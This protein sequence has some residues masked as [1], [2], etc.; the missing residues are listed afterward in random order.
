VSPVTPS[1][2][3]DIL[4]LPDLDK[5]EDA[6]E[7]DVGHFE[8]SL[9]DDEEAP[10]E[11]IPVDTF[12]VDIQVLT[13]SGSNEAA[14][15]LDVGGNELME[16]LPNDVADQDGESAHPAGAELDLHLDT[17]LESDEPSSD[18]ELGDDGLEALPELVNEDGDGD[19]GP[20]HERAYLPSAPEGAVAKGPSYDSEWLLLGTPCS[21][22]WAGQGLV[23]GAAEHLM[24]FGT[25]RR[26]QDLPART[27]TLSL[28][29]LDD[30]RVMLATTRGLLELTPDG[31]AGLTELS[32][33]GR[34]SASAGSDVVELAAAHGG[35][36]ALW[37]RLANGELLRKRDGVWGRHEAGGSV[38]ALSSYEEHVTLLVV[39]HRP[40]LQVSSDGGSSFREI[41][42]PEPA[43]TVALGSGATAVSHGA[44][45]ALADAQ[46]GLCIS[47][48][49]GETFRMVVGAVNV[50]AMAIGQH[51]GEN[52]LFAA[53]YRES[54]DVS[55][56]ISVAF[57]SATPLSIAEL[58]GQPD[59]DAEETGR[60]QA[61][62]F[63]GAELWAAGG[64]GLAKL[65]SPRS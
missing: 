44:L 54:K 2:Q 27:R 63:A 23:L 31:N 9:S 40:T 34:A 1:P 61:L 5:G 8:L 51:A 10:D 56:L 62:V 35:H 4:D 37:A 46:R 26:S 38:R 50:T 39:S 52:R 3:A 7:V 58:A 49:G 19:A 53:L 14:S 28:A 29:R 24:R 11:A 12:E 25:E 57:D 16:P 33:L 47:N 20:E 55:E 18:A 32:E 64:Y 30:D 17:P 48:D 41:L 59:E 42:L 65:R 15:D 6:E 60:T 36:Y 43:A 22:L 45:L 13:D 21:A